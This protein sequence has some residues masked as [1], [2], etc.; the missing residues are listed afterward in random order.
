MESSYLDNMTEEPSMESSYLDNIIKEEKLSV[1]PNLFKGPTKITPKAWKTL[2]DW[3]LEVC[4]HSRRE[5]DVFCL[6]ILY[7]NSY[8]CN[9]DIKNE[10][11]KLIATVCLNLASKFTEKV[12]IKLC[13]LSIYE[14]CSYTVEEMIG[15]ELLVLDQLNWK[16]NVLTPL[17]FHRLLLKMLNLP[18]MREE[19][20]GVSEEIEKIVNQTQCDYNF[21]GRRP[22]EIAVAAILVVY[23]HT[24][25]EQPTMEEAATELLTLIKGN[26]K[27][28][29]E[30]F[31]KML[32][33]IMK[34]KRSTSSE[35]EDRIQR[36][37][38]TAKSKK[39]LEPRDPGTRYFSP[40]ERIVEESDETLRCNEVFENVSSDEEKVK[41]EDGNEASE[42]QEEQFK[43][44]KKNDTIE[45]FNK[46]DDTWIRAIITS[47]IRQHKDWYNVRF[48][49]RTMKDCSVHL[50]E[51][52]LWRFMD[53]TRNQ[54]FRFKWKGLCQAME[55]EQDD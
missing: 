5:P 8:M 12:Q 7:L 19:E 50:S 22:S 30:V 35:D 9:M 54:Y 41:G 13:C 29:H 53:P 17:S 45:Y 47:K 44:P 42:E 55:E 46:E 25:P 37:C 38:E 18:N 40:S 24:N 43:Q 4:T 32:F 36:D 34:E 28:L 39:I 33:L 15:C 51:E 3:M 6:A 14:H 21:L 48:T 49:N 31:L 26:R 1:C 52:T 10:R 20:E 16:L 23:N 2:V 11:L 27:T